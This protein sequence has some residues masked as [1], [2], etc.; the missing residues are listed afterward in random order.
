MGRQTVMVTD[1]WRPPKTTFL[2]EKDSLRASPRQ[3]SRGRIARAASERIG[4][5]AG[6]EKVRW[7]G[8]RYWKT[9]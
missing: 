7:W 1:D 8:V 2:N 9:V 5:L 6:Y 4:L 3:V